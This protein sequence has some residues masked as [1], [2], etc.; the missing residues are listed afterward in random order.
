MATLSRVHGWRVT[1]AVVVAALAGS[2]GGD[3]G[4][5][6]T[7]S[8]Q[9]A[10]PGVFPGAGARGLAGMPAAAAHARPAVLRLPP[11]ELRDRVAGFQPV[12]RAA[13][14]GT[15][16]AA[17]VD[18]RPAVRP[19][20]QLELAAAAQP[21]RIVHFWASWCPPCID[22]LNAMVSFYSG[23]Y[24]GLHARGLEL[25]LISN[26]LRVEDIHRLTRRR[27]LPPPIYFDPFGDWRDVLRVPVLPATVI[28]DREG[29]V[30]ERRMG[31][32]EWQSETFLRRLRGYLGEST[33]T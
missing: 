1:T 15:G 31:Q 7:A 9:A 25:I 28:L 13:A 22:E 2:L 27:P 14:R 17:G 18:S 11:A 3:S 24:Q 26:D 29:R 23:A 32:L 6:P 8:S 19:V 30:L 4:I 20:E 5:I 16:P 12:R 10:G 21:I 33:S